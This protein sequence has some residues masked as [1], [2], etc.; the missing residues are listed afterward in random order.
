MNRRWQLSDLEYVVITEEMTGQSLP[1][2]FTYTSRIRLRNDYLRE[3]AAVAEYLRETMD[4]AFREALELLVQ[5]DI[6]L[7]ISGWDPRVDDD[8]ER[9]IRM[10]AARRGDR[11][12]LVRQLPGE[13]VQHSGGFTVVECDMLSL[14]TVVVEALPEVAPGRRGSITIV[15][16]REAQSTD[17]SFGHSQIFDTFDDSV[18]TRSAS[19]LAEEVSAIGLIR[20]VQGRSRFGPRGITSHALSWR[21]IIGDGRYIITGRKPPVASGAD[22]KDFVTK[23]NSE[24]A[25]VVRSIRDERA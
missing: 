16:E 24:I 19:F 11:G 20:V 12:V 10:L 21:D 13:T 14:A 22:T 17:Y 15:R 3:K 9:C 7:E 25:A 6:R 4:G 2:P 23:I 8:P 5:P 18:R 1:H